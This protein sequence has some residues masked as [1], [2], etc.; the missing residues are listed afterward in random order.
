V[1]LCT[2]GEIILDLKSDDKYLKG[3]SEILVKK[4]NEISILS[5]DKND[6]DYKIEFTRR[7]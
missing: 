1:K 6:A 4:E 2:V 5:M 7:L 3:I